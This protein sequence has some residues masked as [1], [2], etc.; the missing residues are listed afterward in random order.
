MF[1]HVS[2]T[3]NN[4]AL[5]RSDFS[6]QSPKLVEYSLKNLKTVVHAATLLQSLSNQ[7]LGSS[8]ENC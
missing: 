6:D 5:F 3:F 8:A 2:K 1:Y 4:Q 7:P